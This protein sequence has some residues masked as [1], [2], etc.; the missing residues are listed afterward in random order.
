MSIPAEGTPPGALALFSMKGG[1]R[2]GEK[3]AVPSPL[4]TIGSSAQ[5]DVVLADDS[6]SAQHAR[7]E[8]DS[9][10]W[11][12]T[13]LESTNGTAV[14]GVRLAPHVPT[15]LPYGASVRLGGVPLLFRAVEA[16]DPAA[17]RASFVP[18][19]K[20]TTLKEEKPG[21][22]LPVW[23]VVLVLLALAIAGL[24]LF[25]GQA[26]APRPVP[27]SHPAAAPIT[28]APPARS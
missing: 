23:L 3:I 9:G 11:R 20:V 6:V 8:Y 2:Y 10:A 22:R 16:A 7:L 21:F 28:Q 12:I 5:A 13:D 25:R 14:E 24:L 1:P 27:A 15:P 18:P 17:A 26:A 19:P 4:V